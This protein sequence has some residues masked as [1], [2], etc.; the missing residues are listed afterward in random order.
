M[1]IREISFKMQPSGMDSDGYL[2]LYMQKKNSTGPKPGGYINIEPITTFQDRFIYL[3]ITAGADEDPRLKALSVYTQFAGKYINYIKHSPVD[4]PCGNWYY[5]RRDA[6]TFDDSPDSGIINEYTN[7]RTLE[8][9]TG[10]NEVG[11]I[12]G[13]EK[14]LNQGLW[15]KVNFPAFYD[16]LLEIEIPTYYRGDNVLLQVILFDKG[17]EYGNDDSDLIGKM[18]SFRLSNSLTSL[19]ENSEITR[20]LNEYAS[21]RIRTAKSYGDLISPYIDSER[22]FARIPYDHSKLYLHTVPYQWMGHF[23]FKKMMEYITNVYF[24]LPS[25]TS[26][27]VD[28][29]IDAVGFGYARTYRPIDQVNNAFTVVF[30]TKLNGTIK[31]FNPQTNFALDSK[32]PLG[33]STIITQDF[34]PIPSTSYYLYGHYN[35]ISVL[36][37]KIQERILNTPGDRPENYPVYIDHKE[38][39]MDNFKSGFIQKVEQKEGG[40]GWN[41]T[42]R[43]PNGEMFK[44]EGFLQKYE[45]GRFLIMSMAPDGKWYIHPTSD[46]Y[47]SQVVRNG[48]GIN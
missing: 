48:E 44:V 46:F 3:K 25:F 23:S 26:Q 15:P 38:F 35:D 34:N 22:T 2:E 17:F 43:S 41:Y 42:L 40:D 18:N 9:G 13:M 39:E 36:D 6:E 14:R 24:N 29:E 32:N 21:Y 45:I 20:V 33:T 47:Y 28:L 37:P 1:T 12:R 31:E 11:M 10:E 4:I 16:N 7:S 27:L 8:F 19:R 30:F 5:K